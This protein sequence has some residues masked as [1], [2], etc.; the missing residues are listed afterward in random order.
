MTPPVP[1]ST[2][3]SPLWMAYLFLDADI[4]Y[5]L[6]SIAETNEGVRRLLTDYL[7]TL[8][9]RSLRR[10]RHS[11]CHNPPAFLRDFRSLSD[12]HFKQHFRM[13]RHSFQRLLERVGSRL[14]TQRTGRRPLPVHER[15][16]IAL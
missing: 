12:P 13:T 14:S 15:L 2:Y 5:M 4:E 10:R 6:A 9:R 3:S 7:D 8:D 1:P 16:A 11:T